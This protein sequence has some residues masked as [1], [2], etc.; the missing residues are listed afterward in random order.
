MTLLQKNGQVRVALAY[1]EF[2]TNLRIVSQQE[3]Q[4]L[5]IDKIIF[6]SEGTHYA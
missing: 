5:K 3:A 1:Q 2:R 6:A 4:L